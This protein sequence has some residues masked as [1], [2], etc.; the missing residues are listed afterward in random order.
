MEIYLMLIK[1]EREDNDN[2]KAQTSKNRAMIRM[3][4]V[5]KSSCLKICATSNKV[6]LFISIIDD[7]LFLRFIKF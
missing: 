4:D 6:H 7:G 3:G 5:R 1:S 2:N